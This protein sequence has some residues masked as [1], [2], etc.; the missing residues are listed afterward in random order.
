MNIDLSGKTALITGGTHGIGLAIAHQLLDNGCT[1][2][3]LARH[4][5]KDLCSR[6]RCQFLRCDVMDINDISAACKYLISSLQERYTELNFLINNVGGGGRWGTLQSRQAMYDCIEKNLGSTRHFTVH[7]LPT[8]LQ[9]E[10]ARVITISSIYG[11]E[12]GHS[13]APFFTAAKSAQI[14]FM[15]ELSRMKNYVRQ[16]ITFNTICP[17]PIDISGTGWDKDETRQYIEEEI[18]M[19][20]LG[21]PEEVASLALFLCSSSSSYINGATITVD[22]GLSRSY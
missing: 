17:G 12:S 6:Y 18:P 9:A 20:R 5:N 8:L 1:V 14:A 2:W 10:Y 15:K 13:S 22:G 19:G 21:T 16:G 7:L 4:I 11:K 3:V